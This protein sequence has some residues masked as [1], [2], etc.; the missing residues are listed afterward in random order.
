MRIKEVRYHIRCRPS[1]ADGWFFCQRADTMDEVRKAIRRMKRH[2]ALRNQEF[3]IL[4]FTTVTTS[5]VI[6]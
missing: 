6:K 1:P 4:E 5:K 2:A 3:Q